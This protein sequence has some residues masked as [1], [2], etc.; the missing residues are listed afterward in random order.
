M[1]C[2]IRGVIFKTWGNCVS[3][4]GPLA[5]VNGTM[6]LKS[7]GRDHDWMGILLGLLSLLPARGG[8]HSGLAIVD[9]DWHS[10][11][12]QSLLY[13]LLSIAGSIIQLELNQPEGLS[14]A[15]YFQIV[16]SGKYCRQAALC[17]LALCWSWPVLSF[18]CSL[19]CSQGF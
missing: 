7:P 17:C 19:W 3:E 8:L 10:T 16:V 14:V 6:T 9:S 13:R 15:G 18:Q 4:D 1:I 12:A 2:R 11:S 5:F